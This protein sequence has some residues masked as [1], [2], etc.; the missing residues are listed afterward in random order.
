MFKHTYFSGQ[1]L[2][3]RI[4]QLLRAGTGNE[5]FYFMV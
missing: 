1:L 5:K 4:K 2:H 3:I